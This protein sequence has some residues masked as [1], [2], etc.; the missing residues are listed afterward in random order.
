MVVDGKPGFTKEAFETIKN[1]VLD[2]KVYCSLTVDEMSVK[3]HIEIDTQQNMYGYINLGTDCNYDNDEIPVA[4]NALV[5][6]VICMNG[7][8]KH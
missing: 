8:W 4:K 1:K 5:F 7:Y 2:S 6:M 3:R